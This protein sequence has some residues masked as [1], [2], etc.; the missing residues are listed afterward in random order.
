CEADSGPVSREPRGAV[1]PRADPLSFG[2]LGGRT[3][4]ASAITTGRRFG[5]LCTG[6][7]PERN[8][9]PVRRRLAAD[10]RRLRSSVLI[11]NTRER[12]AATASRPDRRTAGQLA[13][14]RL[15]GRSAQTV[16]PV[17]S[18]AAPTTRPPQ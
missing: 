16:R 12:A 9:R 2:K 4:A 8:Y 17:R 7:P 18:T 3:V 11:R 1:R 5:L 14:L 6:H 15:R 10:A 13:A